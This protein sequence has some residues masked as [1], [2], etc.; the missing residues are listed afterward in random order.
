MNTDSVV[1]IQSIVYNFLN[2]IG[3]YDM[4][5]FRRYLQ[6][7]IRGFGNLNMTTVR[8]YSVLYATADEKGQVVLPDDFID[9]KFVGYR[10]K[11][12]LYPISRNKKLEVY[13]SDDPE[14]ISNNDSG[15]ELVPH[16]V[17]GEYV[18]GLFVTGVYTIP[19]AFNIDYTRKVLQ[20]SSVISSRDI[21]IEYISTGIS[22][23][24]NTFVP[25]KCEDALIE[26]LYWRTTKANPK[27][28]RGEKAD[29]K[30]D[31]LEAERILLDMETLPSEK[32]IY[33]AIYLNYNF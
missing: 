24:G 21:V 20:L 29:A 17:D 14:A 16:F 3:D 6:I 7:A 23:D 4:S 5:N 1:S 11:G 15:Y 12:V 2:E 8:S 27:A 30:A 19:Y 9:Y 18:V 32:E 22:A 25:K 31:Y 13:R 26:Y 10:K 28:T 33:D